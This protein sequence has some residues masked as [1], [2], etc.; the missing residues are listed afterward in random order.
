MYMCAIHSQITQSD[1]VGVSRGIKK[2]SL[3]LWFYPFIWFVG[4][5]GSIH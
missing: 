3:G 1:R 2:A 5:S 4:T